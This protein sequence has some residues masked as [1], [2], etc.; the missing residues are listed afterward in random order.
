[1]IVGICSKSGLRVDTKANKLSVEQ[2]VLVA[3]AT[4]RQGATEMMDSF[5][6]RVKNNTQ[7]LNLWQEV[8]VTWYDKDALP[9]PL[10]RM[11]IECNI[12]KYLAMHIIRRSSVSRFGDLQKSL[13]KGLHRGRDE[14]PVT[15][16]DVYG[17]MVRQLKEI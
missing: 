5:I 3:F 14:Y 7:T 12:K 10:T 1:M 2:E 16:Q 17:L 9:S 11:N 15:L 13:L 6:T 4:M 8:S